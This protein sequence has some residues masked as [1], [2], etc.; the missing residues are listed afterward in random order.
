M[1]GHHYFLFALIFVGGV[2]FA[3]MWPQIPQSLGL[4]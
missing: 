1:Q 2:I 3:R 4:P